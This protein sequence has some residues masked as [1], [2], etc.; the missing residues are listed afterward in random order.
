MITDD[1]GVHA[2]P[3]LHIYYTV[4]YEECNYNYSH[5]RY[6]EPLP[7]HCCKG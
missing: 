3:A 5:P 4:S 7:C 1:L 2:M 6:Y